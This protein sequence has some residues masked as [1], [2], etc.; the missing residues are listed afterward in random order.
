M[1]ATDVTAVL[2]K[3]GRGSKEFQ[4]F[5]VIERSPKLMQFGCSGIHLPIQTISGGSFYSPPNL[6]DGRQ[7]K[8]PSARR[9]GYRQRFH[10][11]EARQR[12]DFIGPTKF[13]VE[14]C[15]IYRSLAEEALRALYTSK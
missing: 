3:A 15:L 11:E 1:G 10:Y 14:R 6:L 2:K 9:H 13:L 8:F 7:C 4:A 5:L 12:E